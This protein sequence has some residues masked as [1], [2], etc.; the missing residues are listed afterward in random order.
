MFSPDGQIFASSS[1]D[2]TVRLWNR[3]GELLATLNGHTDFVENVVFSPDGQTIA[4]ISGDK[5]VKL[6][7]LDL[8]DVLTRGCDWA[9]DYL[10]NNPNVSESDRHICD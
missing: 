4:S 8:D 6:W 2:R 5:T 1:Y 3:E 9:Q 10:S 7:S